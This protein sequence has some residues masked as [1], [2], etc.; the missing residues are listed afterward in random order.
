MSEE[1]PKKE[2]G[3]EEFFS[4]DE[5]KRTE[6]LDQIAYQSRAFRRHV[7]RAALRW[8]E[9]GDLRPLADYLESNRPIEPP[10]RK[11]LRALALGQ[12]PVKSGTKKL[13]SDGERR[14]TIAY[15]VKEIALRNN[16]TIYKAQKIYC[17]RHPSMNPE[18]LKGY[19]REFKIKTPT[20]REREEF[21]N[22]PTTDFQF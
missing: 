19:L 18:T 6:V 17:E 13:R 12:V 22:P 3:W 2:D 14:F 9:M 10:M 4:V 7:A 11:F 20:D 16:S 8:A 5:W 15:E 21:Y 1:D